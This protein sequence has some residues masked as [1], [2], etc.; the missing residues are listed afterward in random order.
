MFRLIPGTVA[1]LSKDFDEDGRD[2]SEAST[3]E[4]VFA[5]MIIPIPR[6]RRI[7]KRTWD[8][9]LIVDCIKLNLVIYLTL[10]DITFTLRRYTHQLRRVLDRDH[11][12][13]EYPSKKGL[14]DD[15]ALLILPPHDLN[16]GNIIL[17]DDGRVWISENEETIGSHH[18]L[19]ET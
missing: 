2:V 19:W 8:C 7:V 12:P 10:S 9:M 15:S 11:V 1:K 18:I 5:K 13:D 3:L 4:L 14:F 17:G 16:P 6:I